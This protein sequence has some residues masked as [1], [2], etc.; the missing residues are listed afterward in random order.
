MMAMRIDWKQV[1][2]RMVELDVRSSTSLASGAGVHPNTLYKNG[3][4]LS[5]TVDRL[6]DFLK[7][8]PQDLIVLVDAP[9]DG[10]G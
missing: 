7:C 6:A 8:S 2:H 10:D 9:D 5:T 1:K 4:F 3:P